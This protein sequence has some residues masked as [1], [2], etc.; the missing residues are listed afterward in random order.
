MSLAK[1]FE[2]HHLAA[3]DGKNPFLVRRRHAGLLCQLRYGVD[4]TG[5]TMTEPK[6][7]CEIAEGLV[8][9][10]LTDAQIPGILG[11]NLNRIGRRKGLGNGIGYRRHSL[12]NHF[13]ALLE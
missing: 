11:G 8:R 5:I 10:D 13:E 6:A 3:E 12:H 9:A 1:W 4:F 2:K 7:I